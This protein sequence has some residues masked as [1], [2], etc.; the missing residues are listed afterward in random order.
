MQ[1][2]NETLTHARVIIQNARRAGILFYDA[3]RADL[4]LDNMP[5]LRSSQDA[6]RVLEILDAID[7]SDAADPWG[8]WVEKYGARYGIE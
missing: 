1:I 2:T 7:R 5:A 6:R 8:D 4:L 3:A